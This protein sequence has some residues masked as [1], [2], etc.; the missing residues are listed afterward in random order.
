MFKLSRSRLD[1]SRVKVVRANANSDFHAKRL[2]N[3]NSLFSTSSR[4]VTGIL[5]KFEVSAGFS[6]NGRQSLILA[7]LLG[8][9][10]TP[11]TSSKL[12]RSNASIV[13]W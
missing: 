5:V 2:F 9:H 10:I 11:L 8:H 7:A 3:E 13:S 6:P 1:K 4:E 12:L